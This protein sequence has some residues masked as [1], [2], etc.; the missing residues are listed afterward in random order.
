VENLLFDWKD[1][2]VEETTVTPDLIIM[3]LAPTNQKAACPLCQQASTKVH[4]RYQR[5]LDDL[6]CCGRALRLQVMV[7]R[8]FCLNEECS[9]RL[10]A[11]RISDVTV[12]FARK[13]KRLNR[14]L[15]TIGLALGGEAGARTAENLGIQV[16]PDTLIRRVRA[17][18][19][20]AQCKVRVLGV[21]DFAARRGHNYGTILVDEEARRPIE[22]LPDRES[23][24]LKEWLEK[25]P[26]VE[27]ITR[28][29]SGAYAKGAQEGAPQAIQIAD[30]FHLLQNLQEVV[31]SVLTRNHTALREAAKGLSDLAEAEMKPS[32]PTIV[33]ASEAIA[34]PIKTKAA[35]R[36]RARRARREARYNEVKELKREGLSIRGIARRLGIHR[37]TIRKYL[38]AESLPEQAS[39][40]SRGG[41][42]N[43]YV[44]FLQKR[45][46]EGCRNASSLYR[47]I[48][49]EGYNGSEAT[50]RRWLR[51]RR[52]PLTNGGRVAKQSPK[53]RTPS[54]R[55]ASWWLL[56]C[57][58]E[59]EKE[60]KDYARE[61]TGKFPE[62]ETTQ[63]LA[64]EFQRLVR[65][66]AESSFDMWRELVE[67]NRI[68]EMQ[69]FAESLMNDEA[70]VREGLRSEYSNGQV[71][72]QINRLKMLKRQMYGRANFDLLRLRVL[73][74]Q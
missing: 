66:K 26:E 71:E 21:D 25:H 56:K 28:D 14:T 53:F 60:E 48:R 54:P 29:R 3:R 39:R 18:P 51:S 72:G 33:D 69:R 63:T 23:E 47:E 4:S 6:P 8:F 40:A 38:K 55:R 68:P 64:R 70:A 52:L 9:R 22:L 49:A 13:T 43:H 41:K 62:I 61:L 46:E 65:E 1:L 10:F 15:Q 2:K 31:E 27:I 32:E 37:E 58:E 45:L 34:A 11:E 74:A 17:L 50:L 20:P 16:S 42:V 59:L 73:Y 57:A 12:P 36:S 7:R 67:K 5:A 30:R 35:E 24:R 44:E 19:E